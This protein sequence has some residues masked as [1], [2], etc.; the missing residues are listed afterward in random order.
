MVFLSS[1]NPLNE[2]LLV[3]GCTRFSVLE[4]FPSVT[5]SSCVVLSEDIKLEQG[6]INIYNTL[7]ASQ[8]GYQ[9]TKWNLNCNLCTRPFMAEELWSWIF[10]P[11]ENSVMIN[12][13][14]GYAESPNRKT[15]IGSNGDSDRGVFSFQSILLI[16]EFKKT[17]GIVHASWPFYRYV[18]KAIFL[19]A[20]SLNV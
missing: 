10:P 13:N 12:G 7:W 19:V 1:K 5:H 9:W 8:T 2:K 6:Y 17:T 4:F 16:E 20:H 15:W 14:K 18:L 3:A 11:P